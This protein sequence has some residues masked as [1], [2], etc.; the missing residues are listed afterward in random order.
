MSWWLVPLL[1]GISMSI[2]IIVIKRRDQIIIPRPS[3]VHKIL[4][5]SPPTLSAICSAI[6]RNSFRA[7]GNAEQH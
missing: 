3:L 7:K 5:G 4:R 6:H 1:C 2:N